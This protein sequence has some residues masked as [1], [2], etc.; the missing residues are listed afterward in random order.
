VKGSQLAHH[1]LICVLLIGMNGLS[2][3]SEIV[4]TREL[5]AAMT[6]KWALAG[7]FPGDEISF[8]GASETEESRT[9]CDEPSARCD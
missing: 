3:L 8:R 5:L 6:G 2:M 7:M 9:G 1:P 4:E